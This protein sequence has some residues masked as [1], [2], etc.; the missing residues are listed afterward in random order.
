MTTPTL[1]TYEEVALRWQCSVRTVKRAVARKK[2]KKTVIQRTVRF[3]ASDVERAEERM[4]E[5]AV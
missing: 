1:L 5:A 2:L 3:R 4:T